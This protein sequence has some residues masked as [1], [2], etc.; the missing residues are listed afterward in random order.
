MVRIV[1]C[2]GGLSRRWERGHIPNAHISQRQK[3]DV[4]VQVFG[5]ECLGDQFQVAYRLTDRDTE[6]VSIDQSC[7]IAAR[8]EPFVGNPQQVAVL[9]E[10]HTVELP[11]SLKKQVVVELVRPVFLCGQ[12]INASPP[13]LS[14]NRR[15]K[16]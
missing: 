15:R 10:Q 3:F 1:H 13:E 16:R 4:V 5:V 9:T 12:D 2:S 11:G 14:R 6:L 7:E 8:S